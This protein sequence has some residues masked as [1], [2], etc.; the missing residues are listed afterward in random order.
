[1]LFNSYQFIFGFLPT[2]C[3]AYFVAVHF[4]GRRGR[5][6]RPGGWIAVLLRLVERA[7]PVDFFVVDRM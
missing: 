7:L 3:I 6:G 4:W 1:M 5:N 2:V